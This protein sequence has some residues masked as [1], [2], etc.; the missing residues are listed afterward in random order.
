MVYPNY[1]DL[2]R[3]DMRD[4]RDPITQHQGLR[5]NVVSG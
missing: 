2:Q 3:F 1:V 5:D 4:L